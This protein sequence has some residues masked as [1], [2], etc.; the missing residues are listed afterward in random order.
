LFYVVPAYECHQDEGSSSHISS[1]SSPE[2]DITVAHIIQRSPAVLDHNSHSY[3]NLTPQPSRPSSSSSSHALASKPEKHLP[4]NGFSIPSSVQVSPPED[5]PEWRSR[6]S[7]Q[8]CELKE[9][10]VP[11]LTFAIDPYSALH[12]QPASFAVEKDSRQSSGLDVLGFDSLHP[13]FPLQE[14]SPEADYH[15]SVPSP[16][17]S[18]PL[19]HSPRTFTLFEAILPEHREAPQE[20]PSLAPLSIFEPEVDGMSTY[21][22]TDNQRSSNSVQVTSEEPIEIISPMVLEEEYAILS[23]SYSPPPSLFDPIL[24]SSLSS[25]S[26]AYFTATQEGASTLQTPSQA[27]VAT[28]LDARNEDI[29]IDENEFINFDSPSVDSAENR[30]PDSILSSSLFSVPSPSKSCSSTPPPA[31]VLVS[32]ASLSQDPRQIPPSIDANPSSRPVEAKLPAPVPMARANWV[33][34]GLFPEETQHTSASHRKGSTPTV[35]DP[36]Y[37]QPRYRDLWAPD[38][39]NPYLQRAESEMVIAKIRTNLEIW[40]YDGHTNTQD[41]PDEEEVDEL[42][43][44]DVESEDEDV[45]MEDPETGVVFLSQASKAQATL[46]TP[47]PTRKRHNKSTVSASRALTTSSGNPESPPIESLSTRRSNNRPSSRSIPPDAFRNKRG[48]KRKRQESLEGS[49][50]MHDGLGVRVVRWESVLKTFIKGKKSSQ[51]QVSLF[52]LP[53]CYFRC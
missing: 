1:R 18:H 17:F 5:A 42:E 2:L 32:D 11:G 25:T 52:V 35:L 34:V 23:R 16:A 8:T 47:T 48:R 15:A 33:D 51:Q 38:G 28:N 21:S 7:E 53:F 45:E 4:L 29:D 14:P 36:K 10:P 31:P 40:Y 27:T 6:S 44:D 20:S 50:K 46:T 43:E 37:L 26:G 13:I 49:D 3:T 39:D 12:R 19:V 24:A 30:Q 9:N 22:I 41:V